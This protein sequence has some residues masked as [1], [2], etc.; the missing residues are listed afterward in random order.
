MTLWIEATPKE[1]DVVV[2]K[3]QIQAWCDSLLHPQ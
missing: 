2:P 3:H 1:F